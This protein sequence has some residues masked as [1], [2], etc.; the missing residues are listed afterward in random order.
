VT[1]LVDTNILFDVLHDDPLWGTWSGEKLA[2]HHTELIINPLIYAELCYGAAARR[3]VEEIVEGFALRLENLPREALFLC[4][5]AYRTYRQRGG[6]KTAPL[7]DFFI[8]AH[9]QALSIPIL[10][11]DTRRYETYFP[12]AE[13]ICP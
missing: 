13:L 4:A 9:A 10:T 12:N 2:A 6:I 8:G 11:R 7:A 5:Q 1:V 3:E